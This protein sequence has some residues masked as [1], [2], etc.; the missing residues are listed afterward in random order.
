MAEEVS[1]NHI[2]F[3]NLVSRELVRACDRRLAQAHISSIQ[4]AESIITRTVEA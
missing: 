3:A 2:L 4:G 1:L